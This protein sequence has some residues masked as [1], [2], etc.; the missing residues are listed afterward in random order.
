[1]K[2]GKFGTLCA[3]DHG[4]DRL[5]Q[6]L[7]DNSLIGTGISTGQGQ[8]KSTEIDTSNNETAPVQAEFSRNVPRAPIVFHSH[9]YARDDSLISEPDI[10]F[11]K[12]VATVPRSMEVTVLFSEKRYTAVLPCVCTKDWEK[13]E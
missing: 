4:S 8:I 7:E 1:M 12:I 11:E 10:A 5:Q 6:I 3:V 13:N 9:H 2:F